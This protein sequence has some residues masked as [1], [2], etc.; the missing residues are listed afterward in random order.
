MPAKR[1]LDN[2]VDVPVDG[3]NPGL[4][5]AGEYDALRDF[6]EHAAIGLQW[7][8]ADGI[9]IRANAA[10]LDLLGY[11][12]DQYVGHHV[13]EFHVDPEKPARILAALMAGERVQNVEA[14]LRARTGSV[15]HVL[16]DSSGRFVDGVFLHSRCLTR[17]V[18]ALALAERA[19]RER[20]DRYQALVKALPALIVTV[21]P[22]SDFKNT[23]ESYR[24]YTGL[25]LEEAK[26]WA[27][28]AVIHPD[29]MESAM[30]VWTPALETG[31]PMQNE[32]RLR[33]HDGT[34]RWYLVQGV[35]V[36][37]ES[38]AIARWVTVAIDIDDRKRT[39]VHERYLAETTAKLVS[40][41]DSTEMLAEIARLAVPTLAD[42]CAIGLF[43]QTDRTARVETAGADDRERPYVEAIHLRSWLAKPG[44]EQTIGAVIA[45][46]EPVFIP[47]FSSEFVTASAPDEEQRG[48][49][50]A[51]GA[52]SVI[53]VP[54]LA[55]GEPTGMATFATT[56]SQRRYTPRD[57]W[58]LT[59]VA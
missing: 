58:L 26:N 31:E 32:M 24:E 38:G 20:N 59:E 25:T 47:D 29:D 51:I 23:S 22:S 15:K 14:R 42:I 45:R 46:G 54:L 16:I 41:L 4:S 19:A 7:I 49:G 33:R 21:T 35:P 30:R 39:E 57:L 18:G 50:L 48:V 8:G 36:R 2:R 11:E 52:G 55:R 28:H 27:D 13:S 5:D 37:D 56:R 1:L 40:P 34:Y 43:D 53:C 12:A 9:I 17:E 10:Q 6:F 44:S 3:R